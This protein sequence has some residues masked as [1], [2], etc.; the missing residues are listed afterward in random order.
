[1]A[2]MIFMQKWCWFHFPKY[3]SFIL[4]YFFLLD[5]SPAPRASAP[6]CCAAAWFARVEQSSC[7]ER[8]ARG[9]SHTGE[10]MGRGRRCLSTE[11]DPSCSQPAGPMRNQSTLD[12]GTGRLRP[13]PPWEDLGSRSSVRRSPGWSGTG[14]QPWRKARGVSGPALLPAHSSPRCWA[15][16]AGSSVA[17]AGAQ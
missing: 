16:P 14:L 2:L 4:H 3:Y 13:Q 10:N 8:R 9:C 5:S 12:K 6:P 1:M 11:L 17:A 7:T 15:Q